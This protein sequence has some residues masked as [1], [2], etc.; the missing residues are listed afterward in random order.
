M[1]PFDG[2]AQRSP[3]KKPAAKTAQRVILYGDGGIGKTTLA[4]YAP[5]PVLIDLDQSAGNILH[6]HKSPDVMEPTTWNDLMNSLALGS[7]WNGRTIV[8]DNLSR[9]EELA[10]R[11]VLDTNFGG[12]AGR[13]TDFGR[14]AN[15]TYI[16]MKALHELLEKHYAAGRSVI[17]LAHAQIEEGI[18]ESGD[19]WKRKSIKLNASANSNTRQLFFTWADTVGYLHMPGKTLANGVRQAD[20]DSRVVAF[21]SGG[22]IEAKARPAGLTSK[23]LSTVGTGGGPDSD[24]AVSFW[25]SVL[26]A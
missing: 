19:N 8:I 16:K 1:S 2:P 18:N 5:A 7:H 15:Q 11:C 6:I 3:F 14:G 21:A 10:S 25:K 9:A 22:S 26:G 4:L 13:F 20:Q 24:Q 12:D 23:R 17:C